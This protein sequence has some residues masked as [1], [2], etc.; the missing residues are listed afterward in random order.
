MGTKIQV[1]QMLDGRRLRGAKIEQG[2][3]DAKARK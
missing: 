1:K 2:V 3:E